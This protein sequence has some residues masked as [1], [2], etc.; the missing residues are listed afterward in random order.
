MENVVTGYLLF[1]LIST[2]TIACPGPGTLLTITNTL[3]YGRKNTMWGILGTVLG[4]FCI[5]ILS[6]TSIGAILAHDIFWF[7][8][9]KYIGAVYLVYLSIKTFKN[10]SLNIDSS[11]Q[12]QTLNKK[13]NKP[14]IFFQGFLTS[15]SN[16]KTIIFFIALFPQFIHVNQSLIPQLL[17]LSSLFCFIALIIHISYSN[18]IFL[19]KTK[20]LTSKIQNNL[21]KTSGCIFLIL[22]FMLATSNVSR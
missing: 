8:L 15:L 13:V 4:M 2:I 19:F 6:A 11:D 3:N 7:S 18:F 14:K 12:N 10:K 17:T 9:L 22:S 20:L 5:A 21:N 1:I 16:P